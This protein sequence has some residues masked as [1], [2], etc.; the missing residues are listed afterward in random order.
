MTQHRQTRRLDAPTPGGAGFQAN[1]TGRQVGEE[2]QHTIPAQTLGHD[3][4][5]AL[6]NTMN[7]EH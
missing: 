1:H 5:S 7:L 3:N 6:V 2:A 4:L